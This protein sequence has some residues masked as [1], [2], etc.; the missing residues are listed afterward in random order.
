[1]SQNIDLK[2]QFGCGQKGCGNH[3][4]LCPTCAKSFTASTDVVPLQKVHELCSDCRTNPTQS[5][6]ICN[7]MRITQAEPPF[8]KGQVDQLCN[9]MKRW[10][11]SSRNGPTIKLTVPLNSMLIGKI[12]WT[13]NNCAFSTLVLMLSSSNAGL[14]SIN[15]QIFAGYILAVIINAIQ[16]TG[17]C[18]PIVLE[19]FRLELTKLSGNPV[20][21]NWSELVEFHELYNAC[22]KYK[23]IIANEVEIVTPNDDNGSYDVGKSL[24]GKRGS[25]LVGAYNWGPSFYVL[26]NGILSADISSKHR[27]RA[28][29]LWKRDHFF[30]ILISE[31]GFWLI[32]GKGGKRIDEFKA[33][34]TLRQLT[35][36]QFLELCASYGAF[37]LFE[38]VPF[39]S[40][41]AQCVLLPPAS[42]A[43]VAQVLPPPPQV[44]CASGP[45]VP[46][47]PP[48][49]SS[50]QV[51]HGSQ[52][53]T[54][55]LP[56]IYGGNKW[57]LNTKSIN[58]RRLAEGDI[59]G[60]GLTKEYKFGESVFLSK[61]ALETV[62]RTEYKGLL[63][64]DFN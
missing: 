60:S 19:A 3:G 15:Q 56:M 23:I 6:S 14:N 18:D 52:K 25:T 32:D 63:N 31:D 58:G 41:N 26:A 53:H 9:E 34:S 59:I 10:F 20:W 54:D 44:P 1:M 22:V 42:S 57:F 4:A 21:S 16:E 38:E 50:A 51:A 48:P 61:D 45:L 49:A 7:M 46:S 40:E 33:E 37:Y 5:C 43:Q 35:I 27:I 17:S 8:K 12:D 36:E 28:V 24:N 47:P 30:T 62:L 13:M 11:F 55:N 29:V 2:Q 64:Q 39:V